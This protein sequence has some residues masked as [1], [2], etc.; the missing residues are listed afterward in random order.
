MPQWY[1]TIWLH[2]LSP[3]RLWGRIVWDFSSFEVTIWLSLLEQDCHLLMA[4]PYLEHLSI[5]MSINFMKSCIFCKFCLFTVQTIHNVLLDA[6]PDGEAGMDPHSHAHTGYRL[7]WNHQRRLHGD[8]ITE[9]GFGF[10]DFCCPVQSLLT[11]KTG[12]KDK[13]TKNPC[14][15]TPAL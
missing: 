10:G 15:G 11:L 8:F 14:I 12:V 9:M 3:Q 13:I 5:I 2:I 1:N 6:V 4:L 7:L